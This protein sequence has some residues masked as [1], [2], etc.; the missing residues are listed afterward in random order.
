MKKVSIIIAVLLIVFTFMSLTACSKEDSLVG[1]WICETSVSGY[2]DI[3]TL[4]SDGTAVMDSVNV[5]WYVD[6]DE[7]A[8]VFISSG[9]TTHTHKCF[10]EL[11][12]GALYLDGLE[13]H[14]Q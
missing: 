13:Y 2:P 11:S 9:L 4:N 10:Y 14:K 12:N 6:E 1:T 3:M 7:G 5:S 8:F